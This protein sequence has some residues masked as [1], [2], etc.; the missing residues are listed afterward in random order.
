M[1]SSPI[2]PT[3]SQFISDP[4]TYH[5]QLGLPQHS[6]INQPTLKMPSLPNPHATHARSQS[7]SPPSS[8]HFETLPAPR[9]WDNVPGPSN[10][11]QSRH[12]REFQK[13]HLPSSH[14][15]ID[16]H[17][18]DRR[19]ATTLVHSSQTSPVMVPDPIKP[20]PTSAGAPSLP[21]PEDGHITRSGLHLQ[22]KAELIKRRSAALSH[23]SSLSQPS[24]RITSEETH[25]TDKSKLIRQCLPS[26]SRVSSS[27]PSSSYHFASE[28]ASTPSSSNQE[29]NSSK[30]V[31]NQSLLPL[32][33]P[34]SPLRLDIVSPSTK[35]TW[36]IVDLLPVS[37]YIS[38]GT[39]GERTLSCH[40]RG[41]ATI[42]VHP[43]PYQ[44]QAFKR[45]V[46]A[47]KHLH[48]WHGLV[49]LQ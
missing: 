16:V 20:Y 39:I 7:Q 44:H 9:T 13:Y 23:F 19:P 37:R 28:E 21:Q 4:R 32:V 29:S 38:H 35:C 17:P 42:V 3:I 25:A 47:L 6:V 49:H 14:I 33:I 48:L 15:D 34:P 30:D 43:L 40:P 46:P 12:P 41:E 10:A 26:V 22:R 27:S 36:S 5:K 2:P 1:P 11:P 45:P 18:N 24:C 31:R 8:F